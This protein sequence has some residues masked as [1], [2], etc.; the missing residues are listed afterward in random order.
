MEKKILVV[1][2]EASIRS[3]LLLNL[4]K[5]GYTA[6]EAADGEQWGP[7][8]PRP[9]R[10]G[11]TSPTAEP[12]PKPRRTAIR[13]PRSSCPGLPRRIAAD[14]WRVFATTVGLLET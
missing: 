1:D 7:E 8:S 5:A 2:D 9:R 6:L 4:R 3:L 13:W 11:G 12:L 10:R 14:R